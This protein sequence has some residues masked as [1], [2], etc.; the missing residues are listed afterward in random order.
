MSRMHS[1][2]V[3]EKQK[4]QPSQWYRTTLHVV[5]NF[6]KLLK[7]TFCHSKLHRWV[8]CVEVPIN[9]ALLCCCAI[10]DLC[11]TEENR[12]LEV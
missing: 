5:E 10:F 9:I 4:A 11:E 1:Y 6:G 3:Q 8:G 2:S 7:D 12:D